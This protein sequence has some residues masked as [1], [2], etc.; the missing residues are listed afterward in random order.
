M[1]KTRPQRLRRP[2]LRGQSI[3]RLIPN[4]LTLLALCSGLSAIRFT[5]EGDFRAAVVAIILA[6]IIDGLDGRIARLIGA[7]SRFGAELDSLSDFVCFGVVPA[8]LQYIWVMSRAGRI[9]WAV[10]LIYAVSMALRLAR[11]N[12]ALDDEDR[13][14]WTYNYFTGVPAPA[15]AALML[16]PVIASFELPDG[17]I[18]RPGMVGPW[19]LLI[20]ALMVSR[21]PTF[22]MKRLRIANR[23]VLPIL[24]T[25]VV[26][27]AGLAT[28][29]WLTMIGIGL[30]Y[31][32]SIP[33]AYRMANRM[34][35]A[36]P[37]PAPASEPIEQSK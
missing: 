23:F 15:A 36:M 25:V 1:L 7:T 31:M 28:E 17:M 26:V 19:I 21:I 2:R 20:A 5:L 30:T 13:P 12:T 32:A 18:D 6:G 29:P 11:F 27:A 37:K 22:S 34:R 16:L 8:I 10:A 14:A 9:G 24:L 33:F 4:M 3:N 35:R